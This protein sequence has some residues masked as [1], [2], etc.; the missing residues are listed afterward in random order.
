MPRAE[1]NPTPPTPPPAPASR[2]AAKV[3]RWAHRRAEPRSLAVI[4]MLYLVAAGV[5]TIGTQGM[6]GLIAPDVY[7]PAAR[8]LLAAAGAGVSIL[9]PMIRLSQVVPAR[10]VRATIL[11]ALVLAGPLHAIIWSQALPW[12][13]DWSPAVG[14][15]L[16]ILYSGWV[17]VIGALLLVAM[18]RRRHARDHP[19]PWIPRTAWMVV[20]V[21]LAVAA[22]LLHGIDAFHAASDPRRVWVPGLFSPLSAIFEIAKDRTALGVTALAMPEHWHAA[23]FTL[24]LGITL[25]LV[26]ARPRGVKPLPEQRCGA[27]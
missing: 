18:G 22:P 20:F 14:A 13:A 10:P 24:A 27:G 11:D 12:M 1:S 16:S 8:V 3:D 4:W 6:L 23:W 2:P 25:F 19:A 15:V 7:R 5:L 17:L 9:W 26:A 21:F